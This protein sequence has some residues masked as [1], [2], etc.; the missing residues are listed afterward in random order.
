MAYPQ[1]TWAVRTV[2]SKLQFYPEE[3]FVT[4]MDPTQPKSDQK[5]TKVVV[6]KNGCYSNTLQATLLGLNQMSKRR[7]RFGFRTFALP[8]A[9]LSYVGTLSCSI[10]MCL[11]GKDSHCKVADAECPYD[12]IYNYTKRGYLED[13]S[14]LKIRF[15]SELESLWV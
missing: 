14:G 2:S 1:I 10:R 3:C 8:P 6:V 9:S 7:L 11:T 5:F 4:K 12:P 15:G 13:D